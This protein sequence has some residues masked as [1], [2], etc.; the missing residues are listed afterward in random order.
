MASAE[1]SPL[2][3]FDHVTASMTEFGMILISYFSSE[4]NYGLVETNNDLDCFV[5]LK[6]SKQMVIDFLFMNIY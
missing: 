3:S 5:K 1:L 4:T 2:M 6:Y